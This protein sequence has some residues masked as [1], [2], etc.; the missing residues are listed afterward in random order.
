MK[1]HQRITVMLTGIGGGGHGEQI[2]KALKLAETDYEI[3]GCDMSPNSL[4][5]SEELID[6]LQ[7]GMI[8]IPLFCELAAH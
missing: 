7:Q 5:L 1:N 2:L 3:I 8:T 4:G 6:I